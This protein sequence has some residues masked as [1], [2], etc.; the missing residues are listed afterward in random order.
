MELNKSIMINSIITIIICAIFVG[1]NYFIVKTTVESATKNIRHASGEHEEESGHDESEE[2]GLI[3]DLGEFI[4][5]LG[6]IKARR[7]LK[8]SVALELTRLETDP[9]SAWRRR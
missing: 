1:S 7:Y 4:L 5:N 6:D 8:V 2:P 9:R 3:V